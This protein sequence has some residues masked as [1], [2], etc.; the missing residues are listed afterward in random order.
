LPPVG[1]P[2]SGSLG[3]PAGG[4]PQKNSKP[5]A[6]SHVSI[7][8]VKIGLMALLASL[9]FVPLFAEVT[10]PQ[11]RRMARIEAREARTQ[12]LR[13]AAWARQEA[14]EARLDAVRAATHAR[15]ETAREIRQARLEVA[16]ET[17]QAAAEARRAARQ[18]RDRWF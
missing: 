8:M 3:V 1:F 16:R 5:N 2:R 11:A 6:F 18:Y 14:R 17:R 10:W 15:L 9:L 4:F 12:A 13:D 7:R